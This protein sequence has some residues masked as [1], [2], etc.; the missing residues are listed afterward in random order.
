MN[1]GPELRAAGLGALWRL[2]YAPQNIVL[3]ADL[4]RDFGLL[5][6]YF[7]LYRR[8]VAEE[9]GADDPDAFAL[10]NSS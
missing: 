1:K 7:G 6:D 10:V 9:L 2:Y 3:R 8:R 4:E 5:E